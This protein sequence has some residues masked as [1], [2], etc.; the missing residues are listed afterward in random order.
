LP[1]NNES[2]IVVFCQNFCQLNKAL[3]DRFCF[4]KNSIA[5]LMHT[6]NWKETT[7]Q[8]AA[9][10]RKKPGVVGEKLLGVISD[11]L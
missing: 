9:G 5:V 2:V 3:F 6:R 8:A 4:K 11:V 7:A 1:N 10:T